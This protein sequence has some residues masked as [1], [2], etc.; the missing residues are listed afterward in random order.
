MRLTNLRLKAKAKAFKAVR[1]LAG[2]S[3]FLA[4]CLAF[5]LLL[6][7]H[8]LHAALQWWL[9]DDDNDQIA[10]ARAFNTALNNLLGT[11]AN[12]N[13]QTTYLLRSQMATLLADQFKRCA[14]ARQAF[15][16]LAPKLVHDPAQ[17]NAG[18][19]NA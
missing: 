10:Y 1:E 8:G 3:K 18:V 9:A 11:T 14:E 19:E 4:A 6:R 17:T 15:M 16:E 13:D 5:P 7:A 2:D 12:S